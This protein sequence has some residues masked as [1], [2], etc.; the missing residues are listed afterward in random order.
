MTAPLWVELRALSPAMCKN[1]PV[2]APTLIFWNSPRPSDCR[3]RSSFLYHY[4]QYV[5]KILS[6]EPA[7]IG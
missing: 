6:T 1:P 7:F 2:A 4:Y 3:D 5:I